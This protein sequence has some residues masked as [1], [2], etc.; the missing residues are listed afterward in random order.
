MLSSIEE[1]TESIAKKKK[2][3]KTG[4]RQSVLNRKAELEFQKSF[5]ALIS[6]KVDECLNS[7]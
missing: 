2:K 7:K 3:K 1:Y 6:C 5:T 4:N